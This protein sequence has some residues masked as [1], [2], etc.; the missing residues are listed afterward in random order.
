MIADKQADAALPPKFQSGVLI[1]SPAD[2]EKVLDVAACLVVATNDAPAVVA[3]KEE[4]G[5]E[6][7]TKGGG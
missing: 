7:K 1:A 6:P 4:D 3:K 2:L 5:E